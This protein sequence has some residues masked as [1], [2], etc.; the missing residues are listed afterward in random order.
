MLK[1]RKV[2][3]KNKASTSPHK[4]FRFTKRR[5]AVRSVGL[6]GYV[7]FNLEVLRTVW[8][9]KKVF[10]LLLA[11]FTVALIVS[12]SML[13]TD[14]YNALV[15]VVSS[16]AQSEDD[17]TG[18][19]PIESA[20]ILLSALISGGSADDA[21]VQIISALIGV[22]LWLVV[23]WMLRHLLAGNSVSVRD[24][25]YSAG[26][27]IVSTLVLAVVMLVQLLPAA[28]AALVFN[29]AQSTKIL[30]GGVETMVFAIVVGLLIILSLYWIVATVFAAI[31]A[32][33]PGT[34]PFRALSS[35]SQ[36]VMG[37]RSSLVLRFIW[38]GLGVFILWIIVGIPVILLDLWIKSIVPDI[39]WLPIVPGVAI[40]LSVL[41]GLYMS[42]YSYLLYRKVVDHDAATSN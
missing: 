29:S 31:I 2:A 9:H 10:G 12:G 22:F 27:P 1:K 20:G 38:A 19:L 4:S 7:A 30:D 17:I 36:I 3:G 5:D 23:V 32:T 21:S 34:Y 26:A 35:A 6:P 8:Q 28:I 41:S 37:R 25:L 11:I 33:L 39:N 40:I 24:G 14:T 42:A 18:L 13:S 16:N 15:D